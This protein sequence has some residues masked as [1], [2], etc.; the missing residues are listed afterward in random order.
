MHLPWLVLAMVGTVT[1]LAPAAGQSAPGRAAE[2]ARIEVHDT[3][4]RLW[5]QDAAGDPDDNSVTIMQGETVEFAFPEGNGTLSHNVVFQTGPTSCTQR[6]GG[7]PFPA[8]PLPQ[9][10]MG[11]SW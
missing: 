1:A 2:P 8:P 4:T 5:F 11:P 10:A 6:T 3:A 9:F 7:G